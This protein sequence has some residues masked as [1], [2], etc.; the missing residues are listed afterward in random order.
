MIIKI[1]LIKIIFKPGFS[2]ADK[3]SDISGRGV[4]MSCIKEEVDK[5]GGRISIRTQKGRGTEFRI[6]IPDA[7]QIL[8]RVG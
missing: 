6:L 4:G 8:R 5:L 3:I 1:I 2:T 7:Q